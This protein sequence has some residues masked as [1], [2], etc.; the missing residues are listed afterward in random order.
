M[1]LLFKRYASPFLFIDGMLQAGRFSAFVDD[2]IKTTNKEKEDQVNWEY[3]LHRVMEGSFNDFVQSLKNT[4]DDK[5]LSEA[6][7]ETTVQYSLNLLNN[8]IPE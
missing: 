6:T 2:F 1:D 5:N 7:I 4:E 8:F 3:Y